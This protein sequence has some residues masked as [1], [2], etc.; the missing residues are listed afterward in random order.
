MD[1]DALLL[2]GLIVGD[3][4]AARTVDADRSERMANVVMRRYR[5]LVARVGEFNPEAVLGHMAESWEASTRLVA[6]IEA[7]SS[8]PFSPFELR[9]S[10]VH[11][12]H[13]LE[14]V[15]TLIG[16]S[17][18][19]LVEVQQTLK[20]AQA[21]HVNRS[22]ARVGI[23]GLGGAVVVGAAGLPRR[24]SS[25]PRWVRRSGCL[26]R[27]RPALGCRRSGGAASPPAGSA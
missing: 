23:W 21:A 11:L 14:R 13:G 22:L 12:R 10:K 20:D 6:L 25:G 3:D 24:R 8:D 9:H 2:A 26:G 18:D 27:P 4:I 15:A 17:P 7:V 16:A 1:V 5:G 19:E